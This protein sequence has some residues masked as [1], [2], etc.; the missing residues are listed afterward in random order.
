[1]KKILIICFLGLLSLLSFSAYYHDG[2]T[3]GS[4]SILRLGP[5]RH[6]WEL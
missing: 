3:A 4:V 5:C 2:L 1:M 6:R